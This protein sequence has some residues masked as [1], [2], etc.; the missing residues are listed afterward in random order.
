ML[1]YILKSPKTRKLVSALGIDLS[2]F[3]TQVKEMKG[4]INSIEG[5]RRMWGSYNLK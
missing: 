3:L 4:K 1:S 5:L 2:D